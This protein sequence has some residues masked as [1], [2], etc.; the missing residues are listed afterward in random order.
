MRATKLARLVRLTTIAAFL[1]LSLAGTADA[2]IH[3]FVH[4]VPIDLGP[5]QV[6]QGH[7]FELPTPASDGFY[8][9]SERAAILEM[10]TSISDAVGDPMPVGRLMMHHIAFLNGGDPATGRILR[11][12]TCDTLLFPDNRTRVPALAERFF[13]S[14]EESARFELPRGYGYET[15][16]SD[17][18]GMLYMVMNHRP[19][20]DRGFIEYR[21]KYATGPEARLVQAVTPFWF[22]VENCRADPIFDAPGGAPRGATVERNFT[23]TAPHG[24]RIV[25]GQGHV[26]GGAKFVALRQ[27]DCGGREVARSAPTWAPADHPF[28]RVRPIL[29]EPGPIHTDRFLS[30]AGIPVA[31]GQRVELRAVYDNELP[32]T[33]AMATM[34]GAF[35]RDDSVGRDEACGKLPS[36]ASASAAP[37]GRRQFP[38]FE[39]PLVREPRERPLRVRRAVVAVRGQRLTP[40]RL[41]L[42]KGDTVRWVFDTPAGND[43]LHDVTVASGPVG[44]SSPHLNL[45]RS[46]RR[47]FDRPGSY[48]LYCSLHP[49]SMTQEVV[50]EP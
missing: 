22:D 32:H 23:W 50:V 30:P 42:R 5:Y 46:Y 39:V 26:H 7:D 8:A 12:S 6:L 40:D 45:G 36:V 15:R 24:L 48:R 20:R 4:R 27:L 25:A 19:V 21:V 43:N 44:F 37:P 14:G 47:T 33:R 31:K 28:Y 16:G 49:L 34:I 38:R 35:V 10:S 9:G 11:D 1:T 2:G 17:R 13:S 41:R 18:W 3:T 29:H